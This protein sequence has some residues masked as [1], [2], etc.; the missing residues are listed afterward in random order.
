LSAL[1]TIHAG[2]QLA[3][4][5]GTLRVGRIPEAAV[6]HFLH[7]PLVQAPLHEDVTTPVSIEGA[8]GVA[9]DA[10]GVVLTADSLT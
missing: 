5:S 9:H 8:G 10:M 4:G 2:I 7:A 1:L 3:T 6:H